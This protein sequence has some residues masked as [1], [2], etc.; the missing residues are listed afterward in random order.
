MV[1][2]KMVEWRS[3]SLKFPSRISGGLVAAVR[4]G[5][6]HYFSPQKEYELDQVP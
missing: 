4:T 5:A 1:S 6:M 3:P 2:R